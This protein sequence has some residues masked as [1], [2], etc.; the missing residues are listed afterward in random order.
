VKARLADPTKVTSMAPA[1]RRFD[2]RSHALPKHCDS[3]CPRKKPAS[4]GMGGM[5]CLSCFID[6]AK[7]KQNALDSLN[8]HLSKQQ[9]ANAESLSEKILRWMGGT[10]HEIFI[11]TATVADSSPAPSIRSYLGFNCAVLHCGQRLGS[12]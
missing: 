7:A 9:T 10:G 8:F 2:L 12:R 3:R 4:G 5:D 6:Q 1:E 11:A